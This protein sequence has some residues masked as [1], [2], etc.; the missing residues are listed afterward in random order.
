MSKKGIYLLLSSILALLSV[1]D[2]YAASAFGNVI[3]Q[4]F[5]QL[6]SFLNNTY[7]VYGLTF[8]L[9][10]VLFYAIFAAA[11]T[12]VK[13]FAGEHGLSKE[14]KIVGVALAAL[15]N[16]SIFYFTVPPGPQEVLKQILPAFGIFGGAALGL[17]IFAIVYFGF[18]EASGDRNWR[19]GLAAAGVGMV[20]AGMITSSPNISAWGWLLALIAGIFVLIGTFRGG[21]SGGGTHTGDTETDPHTP[22]ERHPRTATVNLIVR[23]RADDHPIPGARV[24]LHRRGW[25]GRRWI[26]GQGWINLNTTHGDG[27]LRFTCRP[28]RRLIRVE[29]PGFQN[30][31]EPFRVRSGQTLNLTV[32]LQPAGGG[33]PALTLI[34]NHDPVHIGQNFQVQ[35]TL[36]GGVVDAGVAG[37]HPPGVFNITLTDHGGHP[38]VIPPP[39][40]INA[41]RTVFDCAAFPIPAT[42]AAGNATA[43]AEC[44]VGGARVHAQINFEIQ[45]G[46]GPPPI[47]MEII[48]PAHAV[49]R[50]EYDPNPVLVTG[51]VIAPAGNYDFAFG[52]Y[53]HPGGNLVAQI[54][55][56]NNQPEGTIDGNQFDVD[57]A[58]LPVGGA[59]PLAVGNYLILMCAR[60]TDAAPFVLPVNL[61]APFAP[62]L[63]HADGHGQR[64]MQITAVVVPPPG[65]GP[66]RGRLVRHD[67]PDRGH[68]IRNIQADIQI[69]GHVYPGVH[70]ND[71]GLFIIN[72]V[73]HGNN[74][75]AT[76]NTA[77]YH[78]GNSAPFNHVA[79]AGAAPTNIGNIEMADNLAAMTV[80]VDPR[81]IPGVAPGARIQFTVRTNGIFHHGSLN[82]FEFDQNVEF[83]GAIIRPPRNLNINDAAFAWN[84]GDNIIMFRIVIPMATAAG[85]AINYGYDIN[86]IPR[87]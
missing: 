19:M 80:D 44:Y 17:V 6:N 83:N 76:V 40:N 81:N 25:N 53:N 57:H 7:I 70:T 59:V 43:D 33:G 74:L 85:T 84:N 55:P 12:K 23:N 37:V 50:Q 42:A 61:A 66:V 22:R 68:P 67:N 32:Y 82:Q 38:I 30:Q 62:G 20:L 69:A 10:F 26:P 52:I 29:S 39:I 2:V 41:G 15:T 58:P 75:V 87:Y 78:P 13:I 64:A 86:P 77:Q 21:G 3:N 46:G 27:T 60:L 63:I 79:A 1:P 36:A 16:L 49:V 65:N 18:G 51:R 35:A 14:G 71:H 72:D 47:Q 45:G 4:T 31:E 48:D 54:G 8:I 56:F 24:H 73:P 11:M 34:V 5:G 28:G 9:L